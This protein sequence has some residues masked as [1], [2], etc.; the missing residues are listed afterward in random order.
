LIGASM[1][2]VLVILL[3][4]LLNGEQA[5]WTWSF[6]KDDVGAKPAGFYFDETGKAPPG[7]WEIVDDEGNRV[8]ARLDRVP[9]RHHYALAVAKDPELKDVKVSVRLKAVEGKLDPAG[10]VMWRY[11]DSE[12]YLCA[13][14]DVTERNVR[15]YRFVEG[16]RIKFGLAENLDVKRGEWYTLRVEHAGKH[17]KVYLDD[18]ALFIEHD[19][20]FR[21]PGKTGVWAKSDSVIYFDDLHVKRLICRD[22]DEAEDDD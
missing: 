20:H 10:G 6:D 16:N 19:W 7:K 3:A 2:K 5:E 1:N 8:L 21:R 17:V 22:Q 18:E 12:N 14:L 4:C 13:R 15:L 11:R 9:K